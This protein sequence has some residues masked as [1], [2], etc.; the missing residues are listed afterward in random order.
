MPS[1]FN[2]I[3]LADTQ[4]GMFAAVSAMDDSEFQQLSNVLAR[5]LLDHLLARL[6]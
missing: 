5:I 1:S 3:Q 2:F 4:F 6:P